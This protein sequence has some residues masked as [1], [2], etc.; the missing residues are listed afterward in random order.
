MQFVWCYNQETDKDEIEKTKDLLVKNPELNPLCTIITFSSLYG[1]ISEI[2]PIDF[3]HLNKGGDLTDLP[4]KK[5]TVYGF[6][7]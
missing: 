7:F 3:D 1:L 5:R 4:S 2:A 6:I